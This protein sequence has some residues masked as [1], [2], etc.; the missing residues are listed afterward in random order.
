MRAILAPSSASSGACG[1]TRAIAIVIA[2]ASTG[3]APTILSSPAPTPE[4]A[5]RALGC[6]DVALSPLAPTDDQSASSVRILYALHN[7]CGRPVTVDFAGARVD[8]WF[9]GDRRE[10]LTPYPA[11]GAE[12]SS[13][14]DSYEDGTEAVWYSLPQGSAVEHHE[15]VGAFCVDLGHLE[16]ASPVPASCFRRAPVAGFVH[17]PGVRTLDAAVDASP[18]GRPSAM[19]TPTSEYWLEND[20][21]GFIPITCHEAQRSGRKMDFCDAFGLWKRPPPIFG[22]IGLSMHRLDLRRRTFDSGSPDGVLSAGGAGAVRAESLDVDVGG[23]VLGPLYVGGEIQFGGGSIPDA[24]VSSAPDVTITGGNVYFAGGA[25]A[26]ASS[27]RLGPFNGSLE[28]FA[29]G[30]GQLLTYDQKG[31]QCDGECQA[32]VTSW[33][34]EP[35]VRLTA[36]LAP[37]WSIGAWGGAGVLNAGDGSIG[38]VFSMHMRS[39]DGTP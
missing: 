27:P 6:L 36:W 26:G 14:L 35:R 5:D 28:V 11:S 21:D 4:P 20:D 24:R 31:S 39:F 7:R 2:C 29:G 32:N 23:Y 1:V 19:I 25:I 12:L 8:A 30:V 38:L 22:S 34:V 15:A 17:V 18:E 16:A 9:E 10:T 33:Y 3:C 13:T 37:H